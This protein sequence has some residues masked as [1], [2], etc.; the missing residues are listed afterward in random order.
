MT[1]KPLRIGW[2]DADMAQAQDVLH[3]RVSDGGVHH[4]VEVYD[5]G[6]HT[7]QS[8]PGDPVGVLYVVSD[9]DLPA[10]EEKHSSEGSMVIDSGGHTAEELAA[11]QEEA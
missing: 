3:D 7:V 2:T 9:E 11:A 8:Q 5:E 4:I 10:F 6:L 1:T